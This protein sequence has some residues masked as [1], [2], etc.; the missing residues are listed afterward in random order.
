MT[1]DK[2]R[3]SSI[4][5][6][7]ISPQEGQPGADR[8]GSRLTQPAAAQPEVPRGA[9]GQQPALLSPTGKRWE[10]DWTDPRRSLP[11]RRA[12]EPPGAELS[13]MQTPP[14]KQ[15]PPRT[16]RAPSG[17]SLSATSPAPGGDRRPR[18]GCRY[19]YR[20][21][22]SAGVCS[23][24]GRPAWSRRPANRPARPGRSTR[25]RAP[26]SWPPAQKPRPQKGHAPGGGACAG[27]AG[28]KE[29]RAAHGTD[30]GIWEHEGAVLLPRFVFH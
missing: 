19:R 6:G 10:R 11:A 18:C 2:A 23:R 9:G 30:S 4:I 12:Q 20:C 5:T 17:L 29:P 28:Q 3:A 25:R 16:R 1:W 15:A 14:P 21:C 8:A 27:E 26:A 24:W 13:L 22:L 7:F